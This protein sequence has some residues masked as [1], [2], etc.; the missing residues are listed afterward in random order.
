M[1]STLC[2]KTAIEI[3]QN[4]ADKFVKDNI[5]DLERTK[6]LSNALSNKIEIMDFS[7]A[8]YRDQQKASQKEY[9]IQKYLNH[10]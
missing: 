6:E 3:A 9:E 4:A 1:I 5:K 2:Q 8:N 7:I 10:G